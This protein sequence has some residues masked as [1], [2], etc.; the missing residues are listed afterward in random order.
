M[1]HIFFLAISLVLIPICYNCTKVDIKK[2]LCSSTSTFETRASDLSQDYSVTEK[3]A[4]FFAKI[5]Y[6]E[7]EIVNIIPRGDTMCPI[8]YIIVFNKGW[9]AISGDKR[10]DIILMEDDEE[11]FNDIIPETHPFNYWTTEILNMLMEIRQNGIKQEDINE[12][13]IR[14]WD[15]ISVLFKKD[16]KTRAWDDDYVWKRWLLG[17]TVQTDSTNTGHIVLTKWGQ[18]Y[19]WNDSHPFMPSLTNQKCYVGCTAVA[20]SQV[21]YHMYYA[22]GIPCGLYH[23]V[24]FGNTYNVYYDGYNFYYKWPITRTDFD[25]DSPRW[26][27]FP[28]DSLAAVSYYSDG[29]EY[30]QDLM[31]DVADRLDMKYYSFGSGAN[32]SNN[33][34]SYFDLTFDVMSLASNASCYNYISNNINL[35]RPIIVTAFNQTGMGHAWII[36]GVKMTNSNYT[37]HYLWEYCPNDG[38]DGFENGYY[39]NCFTQDEAEAYFQGHLQDLYDGA[40]TWSPVSYTSK[41]VWMNWGFDGHY[42]EVCYSVYPYQWMLGSNTYSNNVSLLYNIRSIQ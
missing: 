39:Y 13:S 16:I 38:V 31:I 35:N 14:M 29:L 19:P 20:I 27:Y 34:L 6:P 1:K 33:A 10:T 28:Q 36:D 12:E 30:V 18:D 9:T 4:L 7:K 24:D 2:E 25:P 21:I 5:Q 3:E 8:M 42:D 32:I 41:S 11:L 17:C 22:I 23:T 37:Y 15:E 40:E 26:D